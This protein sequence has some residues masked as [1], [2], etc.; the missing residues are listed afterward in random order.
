[1]HRRA[2]KREEEEATPRRARPRQEEE[3]E[4]VQQGASAWELPHRWLRSLNLL[5]GLA[6][7]TVEGLLALRLG[8]QLSGADAG[9]EF[10]NFI[11]DLT[12]WLVGPFQGIGREREA[13]GGI[14]E[15][16]TPIAMA[17]Y[18]VAALLFMAALGAIAVG[19][20]PASQGRTVR[21]RR[22]S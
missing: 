16:A 13:L 9:N 12:G 14:L 15:P 10:V 4:I 6:I 5:T 21:R 18:L 1:M 11:Y 3:E 2:K 8:F 17:V 7:L 22:V 19:L 20:P